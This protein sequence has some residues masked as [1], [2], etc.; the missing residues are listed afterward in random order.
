MLVSVA[1]ASF[2]ATFVWIL[3]KVFRHYILPS[4]LDSIPGPPRQS[5]LLGNMAIFLGREGWEFYDKLRGVGSV[6]RLDGI[7]G[8]KYLFTYDPKVLHHILLKD[9]QSFR[10]PTWFLAHCNASFGPGLLS[11]EGERHKRQRKMLN[12]AF[13][14]TQMR[15]I[16]HMLYETAHTLQK[17]IQ[18]DI[19][20]KSEDVDV[21]NWLNRSALDSIGRGGLGYSFD[22]LHCEESNG[23]A[24][25]IKMF[26]PA[27]T[28]SAVIA[29]LVEH[30]NLGAAGFGSRIMGYIPIRAV[31][32]LKY[33]VNSLRSHSVKIYNEKKAMI[34]EE[35]KSTSGQPVTEDV[36][37]AILSELIK[38][39]TEA[40]AEDRL[41]DDEIIAQMS[42]FLFAATDT[43]SGMMS[44][45]LHLLSEY[46]EVQERLRAEIIDARGGQDI[47]YDQLV[48]LPYL[49]AV[50][51]ETLRMYPPTP[52]AFK[53]AQR[54]VVVPLAF[55]IRDVNGKEQQQILIP[56]GTMVFI[57][58]QAANRYKEVWGDDA[59]EWN[60]DRWLSP[61]PTSVIDAHIPG[62]YSHLMSFFGGTKSCIGFK[63][64]ET[65]MKVI[66]SVLLEKFRFSRSSKE[67]Y[68]NL[69]LVTFP[70]VG[71]TNPKSQLP[72]VVEKL[73]EER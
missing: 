24:N 70:T 12:P 72:L 35:S 60:P 17:A 48:Q 25:A 53:Q 52:I 30:L 59:D 57:G 47:P 5:F 11:V 3:W 21:L 10:D 55:P 49:D 4:P 68:W 31:K 15:R 27:F 62:V 41:A 37:D 36:S 54:E 34:M 46:P 1:Q 45:I 66:L 67:I 32:Q 50:C 20:G 44:R 38:A 6:S 58:I 9:Q 2:G 39:N 18:G 40:E 64:A 65:E 29:P 14:A 43:T 69:S 71:K 33:A 22:A 61:L 63:F 19:T 51:K 28:D 13:S 23:F 16:I 26:V 7:L 73:S 42:T 56:K 8:S